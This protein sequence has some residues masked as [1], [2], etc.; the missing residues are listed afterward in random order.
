MYFGTGF[1]WLIV[2]T[3]CNVKGYCMKVF[4]YIIFVWLLVMSE[5]SSAG[6]IYVSGDVNAFSGDSPGALSEILN[7]NSNIGVVSGFTESLRDFL[8][9]VAELVLPDFSNGSLASLDLLA[10]GSGSFFNQPLN[11]SQSD[12]ANVASFLSGGGNV[13]L[14]V[15]AVEGNVLAI[16]SYNNFLTNIGSSIRFTGERAFIRQDF[17]SFF[18]CD[19]C[20][21]LSGGSETRAQFIGGGFDG[22]LA[23]AS[24]S[25]ISKPVPEPSVFALLGLGLIGIA[26]RRKRIIN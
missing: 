4:K 17:G 22:Q 24:E 12:I 9:N 2:T 13:F 1:D 8:P 5:V 21:T 7:G 15:E 25:I 16:D 11:L 14:Q 26:V 3:F 23:F 6:I 20:N 19:A 10:I 18:Q